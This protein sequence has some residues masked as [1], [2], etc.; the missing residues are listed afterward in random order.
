MAV[1]SQ[2]GAIGDTDDEQGIFA[3]EKEAIPSP[4]SRKPFDGIATVVYGDNRL[5]GE[6]SS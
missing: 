2:V 3:P 5:L 1:I 4:V 6:S